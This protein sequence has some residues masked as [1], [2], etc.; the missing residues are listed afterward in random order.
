[1]IQKVPYT[2]RF[3]GAQRMASY[4]DDCPG[5]QLEKW[6]KVICCNKCA[7]FRVQRGNL[8]DGIASACRVIQVETFNGATLPLEKETRIRLKLVK[9]TKRYATLMCDHLHLT[10]V[11][12]PDFVDQL[13]EHP[14]KWG[15][16]LKT[17]VGGLSGLRPQFS[18][19]PVH[20]DP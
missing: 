11:W 1:M 18:S 17:Y 15:L 20:N 7:D 14:D 16:I 10:N 9:L 5:I 13:M 3:C 8:T 6:M 19:H 2:C 4:D 12:N